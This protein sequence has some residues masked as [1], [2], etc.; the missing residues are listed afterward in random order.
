MHLLIL[1]QKVSKERSSWVY[2]HECFQRGR[3]DLLESLRRKTSRLDSCSGDR[4]IYSPGADSPYKRA[5]DLDSATG[6]LRSDSFDDTSTESEQLSRKRSS[7]VTDDILHNWENVIG[8]F[9]ARSDY[10][11]PLSAAVPDASAYS[12]PALDPNDVEQVSTQLKEAGT[13]DTAVAIILF[14]LKRNPWKDS[15]ALFYDIFHF[16]T[17]N[18]KLTD[19]INGYNEALLPSLGQRTSLAALRDP[20]SYAYQIALLDEHKQLKMRQR[21]ARSLSLGDCDDLDCTASPQ[22]SPT[23]MRSPDRTAQPL[24]IDVLGVDG[25]PTTLPSEGILR[26][27][28]ATIMRA[29]MSFAVT[30]LQTAA[31]TLGDNKFGVALNSCSALWQNY[32]Q[33]HS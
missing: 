21:Y 13:G 7:T 8:F 2:S 15:R 31:S 4:K 9:H 3:P 23:S 32:A 19:E 26:E 27:N 33:I 28:E 14:C 10:L 17:H 20:I 5:R 18:A 22:I 29:F 16:L 24:K 1:V 6:E 12:M 25:L 30:N 11:R